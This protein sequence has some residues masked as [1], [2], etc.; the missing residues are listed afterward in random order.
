MAIEGD[1]ARDGWRIPA[2]ACTAPYLAG[3]VLVYVGERLVTTPLSARLLL[4]GLGAAGLLWAVLARMV[5]WARAGGN[6]RSV[7]GMILLSYLGGILAL[8]LY[9]ARL[10]AVRSVVWPRAVAGGP[11]PDRYQGILEVLWPI[12]WLSSVLPLVFMEISSASMTRA[13]RIERRRVA[14]S[15][16][17][18]LAVAWLLASLFLLNYVADV[19][20]RKWDLSFQKTTSPSDDASRL[21]ANLNEP[22]EVF[23]F[24]P[25]A[26]EVLE[27]LSGYFEQLATRS[28]RIRVHVYDHVMEPKLA[29]KLG[30]RRNGTLVYRYGDRKEVV[31]IGTEMG[32]A[33][34]KLA[35]LDEEF[36]NKF[37][38]LV[39]ER[40]IAYF[41]TGHGERA[42]PR[43]GEQ[44]PGS[45]VTGLKKILRKQNFTVKPLGL[46]QGL[47]AAVP[48][49]ASLVLVMDPSGDFLPEELSALRRYLEGGGRMWM[50]LDPEHSSN[51]AG[52]LEDYGL[53]FQP[54]PLANARYFMRASY[55]KADRYNL[56]TNRASSHPSVNTLNR[57]ASRLAVVLLE[58][59]RLEKTGG[60][61]P[62]VRIVMT[63][64]SMP[65]TWADEN[66]DME[67]DGE[68]GGKKVYNLEAVV[69]ADVQGAGK[70]P[71]D[72]APPHGKGGAT[73][74]EMRL[75]VLADA[76]ALSDQVLGN[77]GNYFL[78]EDGLKWLLGE[79]KP[80]GSVGTEEDVRIMHTKDE[81]IVWFYTTI[82][83]VP[84][85]VLGIGVVYNR[86]RLRRAGKGGKG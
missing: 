27:E 74:E 44:E 45:G 36:Q 69:T 14:F 7:E 22:F 8:A 3:M 73:D 63:L 35:R 5:N 34:G 10:E 61:K 16:G 4:D 76:D 55:K 48:D 82:F 43:Q 49:D 62:G 39:A 83:A 80:I 25:E 13:P 20:N 86:F 72:G 64:R 77:L 37:L 23:L 57:N 31:Q 47:G 52:L 67:Q 18:G 30:V 59:G 65:M 32:E 78:F 53:R 38:K 12:V 70:A 19:H 66:R 24:Y 79:E 2:L 21:V 1:S 17:S 68:E 56:F 29:R 11:L 26:N 84:L 81:D 85:L 28:N 58:S 50:A 33:R 9:A 51:V 41:T 71:A 54:T 75:I 15:G 6:R 40:R 42:Y 60:K 46:G